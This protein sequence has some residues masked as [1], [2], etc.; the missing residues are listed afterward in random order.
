LFATILLLK[1]T[2]LPSATNKYETSFK[3]PPL[4]PMCN[5]A[6]ENVYPEALMVTLDAAICA[7]FSTT[8]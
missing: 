7:P 2:L 5:A 6:P 1:T 4:F 8:G 3:L